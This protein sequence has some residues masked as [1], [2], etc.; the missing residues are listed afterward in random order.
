MNARS[1][2][3]VGARTLIG[4]C[5]FIYSDYARLISFEINFITKE[6]SRAEP[7]Y[8]N[9]HPQISVLAPAHCVGNTRLNDDHE[10]IS[11]QLISVDGKLLLQTLNLCIVLI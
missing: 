3:R 6:T 7:E 5:I 11:S 10:Y 9:I 1:V 4:G 2:G 8:M